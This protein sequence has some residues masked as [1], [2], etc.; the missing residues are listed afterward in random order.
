M[1]EFRRRPAVGSGLTSTAACKR[2]VLD[3]NTDHG[4]SQGWRWHPGVDD[5]NGKAPATRP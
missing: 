5:V 1:P 3:G 2:A 4:P